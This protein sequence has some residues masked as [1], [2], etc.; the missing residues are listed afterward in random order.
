M[1]RIPRASLADSLCPGLL[2][3]GLS[4]LGYWGFHLPLPPGFKCFAK[5]SRTIGSR[6]GRLRKQWPAPFTTKKVESTPAFL[7]ADSLAADSSD[8]QMRRKIFRR[9]IQKRISQKTNRT[10]SPWKNGS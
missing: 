7:K 8:L 6:S 5:N 1:E 3:V 9:Y 10:V 2:S 4:A